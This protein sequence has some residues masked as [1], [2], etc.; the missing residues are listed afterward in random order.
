[1]SYDIGEPSERRVNRWANA[2]SV[3][4]LLLVAWVLYELTSQPA[5]AVA[6]ICLKFGWDDAR[7]AWWL[8][9]RDANHCR[10][11]ATFWLYLAF[12]LWKVAIAASPMIF[13]YIFLRFMGWLGGGAGRQVVGALITAFTGIFLSALLASWAVLLAC[14]FRLKLWLHHRLHQARRRNAWP[15]PP[16][17]LTGEYN[18]AG[19]LLGT[20]LFASGVPLFLLGLLAIARQALGPLQPGNPAARLV[21]LGFPAGCL[22]FAFLLL[23]L[24]RGA[25]GRRVFAR[26]PGECWQPRAI[27]E[28]PL[29]ATPALQ[30]AGD[31]IQVSRSSS[32]GERETPTY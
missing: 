21:L 14:R 1:M 24:V 2:L 26:T 19:T 27:D 22:L 13:A 11:R 20:T 30:Y 6:A 25:A 10:G 23:W 8:R 7:T 32:W 12:G 18:F 15:P 17:W 3:P 31:E 16:H 5:L 4:A 28:K 9:C 29:R